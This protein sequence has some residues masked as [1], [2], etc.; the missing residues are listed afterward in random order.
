M[1]AD[2]YVPDEEEDFF[3]SFFADKS[4]K[5]QHYCPVNKMKCL[6]TRLYS[7]PYIDFMLQ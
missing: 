1:L 3:E 7:N 6:L 5:I 2:N 4:T